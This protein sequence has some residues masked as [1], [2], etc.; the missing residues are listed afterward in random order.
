[1]QQALVKDNK[2]N[3]KLNS[4]RLIRFKRIVYFLEQIRKQFVKELYKTLM[5]RHLK[6][7]KTQNKVAKCYYFLLITKIVKQVFKEY[8]VY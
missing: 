1:M 8:K 3:F 7:K 4:L 2:I 6:I 5:L